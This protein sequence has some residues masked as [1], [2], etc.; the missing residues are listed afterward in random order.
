MEENRK[1]LEKYF[2]A[3]AINPVLKIIDTYPNLYF[4]IT[5]SRTTKLGDFRVY[6]QKKQQ[7]TVN[8]NLNPYHFLLTFL[9]ELA[10]YLNYKQNGR[11]VKPHGN[12]WKLFY[13]SLILEYLNY[14]CFPDE[15]YDDIRQYAQNPK[16]SASGDGQLFI[17]ISNYDK[18]I[19]QSLKYVFELEKG[20]IF[21]TENGIIYRLEEKRRTRYR[22]I[23]LKN[24]KAYLI[25][26]NARVKIIK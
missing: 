23:N 24:N 26:A 11:K 16:A 19:D 10:H 7:I 25:H 5:K 3:N 13:S 14:G 8:H 2:P 20:T 1:I 6:H 17:K 4:K 18:E 22:C 12:E 15:L 21:A 9:H